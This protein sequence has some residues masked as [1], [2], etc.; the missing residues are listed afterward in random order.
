MNIG[1]NSSIEEI[2]TFLFFLLLPSLIGTV[3]LLTSFPLIT[4]L[5]FTIK[6]WKK[7]VFN[8]QILII[9]FL[10]LTGIHFFQTAQKNRF[11]DNFIN[12]ERNLI[13][14]QNNYKIYDNKKPLDKFFG[15]IDD[16]IDKDYA[17]KVTKYKLGFDTTKTTINQM[18]NLTFSTSILKFKIKCLLG[19]EKNCLCQES[20]YIYYF[21][22]EVNLNF[23][24]IHDVYTAL[25]YLLTLVSVIL[26]FGIN[27]HSLIKQHSDKANS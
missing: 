15:I 19:I 8:L 3:V 1:K 10:Y 7:K 21:G 16:R 23:I 6:T 14:Y 25:T 18:S 20:N 22:H 26:L 24:K 4:N 13:F 12:T 9:S 11:S 5:Y 17:L 2:S 27:I